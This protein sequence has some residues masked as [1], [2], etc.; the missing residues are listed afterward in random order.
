MALI[1]DHELFERARRAYR[2]Y[3]ARHG[4]L[5]A[6]PSRFNSGADK[7]GVYHLRNIKGDLYQFPQS[8]VRAAQ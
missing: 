6:E 5:Y 4:L 1:V 7:H 8:K 2:K 3:C